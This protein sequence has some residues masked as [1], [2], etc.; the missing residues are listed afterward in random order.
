MEL[1]KNLK[2]EKV[3]YFFEQ[4]SRIPRNSGSEKNISD[5]LFKFVKER[6]L[7]VIQDDSLNIII[8]KTATDGYEESPTIIIQGHMDMVCVKSNHSNHN[9]YKDPLELRIVDNKYL[10]A[11]NTTLGADNGI[12]IAYGLAILDSDNIKH[13]KLEFIFTT[14]EETTMNANNERRY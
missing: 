12:A 9:F 4:I 8:K 13:P 11:N 6:N 3:F 10:Y 2:S 1:L 14:E 5:Y 7:S